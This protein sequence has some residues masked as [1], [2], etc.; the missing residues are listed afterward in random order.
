MAAEKAGRISA[1]RGVQGPASHGGDGAGL[2]ASRADRF[3]YRYVQ[4]LV[5][6]DP[7]QAQVMPLKLLQ[8]MGL[9][10]VHAAALLAPA[11]AVFLP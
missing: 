2:D 4:G 1:E 7:L 9:S 8:T 10:H 6:D 3:R 11:I 5:H